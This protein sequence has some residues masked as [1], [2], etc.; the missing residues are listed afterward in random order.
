[1]G[2]KGGIKKKL[3]IFTSDILLK[4][5]AM[6]LS[7][8]CGSKLINKKPNTS[9]IDALIEKFVNDYNVNMQLMMELKE[10]LDG[11]EEE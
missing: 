7:D 4:E 5:W 8:A 10:D 6:D 9:K 1:M 2:K 3:N 11:K